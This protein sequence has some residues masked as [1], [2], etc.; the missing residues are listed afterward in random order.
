MEIKPISIPRNIIPNLPAPVTD[1]T[2]PPVVNGIRVP[3]IDVPTPTIDY[4][5]IDVPTR[6]EFEGQVQQPPQETED[7]PI[8]TRD[9]PAPE[10]PQNTI[11]VPG[12]GEV[13]VPDAA[14]LVTAGATAVVAATVTMTA[15]IVLNQVKDRLLGPVLERMAKKKKVK[16]KQ[17]KPVLHFVKVED[18]IQI[19]EYSVKGTRLRDKTENIEQ[20]LRDQVDLDSLYELDNKLLIDDNIKEMFSR[21]GEKR[22]KKHFTP[23]A[24]IV[25]KLSARIS[26]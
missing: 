12:V 21:E 7:N 11:D 3:V 23:S 6:E 25:K 18:G 8:D 20:Y 2:P 19:F 14:P 1:L 4:P 10:I 17:K 13:P 9:L 15:T 5:T 26:L 22:F 16:I 24:A